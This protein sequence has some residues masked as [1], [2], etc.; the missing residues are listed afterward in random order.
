MLLSHDYQ[1]QTKLLTHI[2]FRYPK[3]LEIHIEIEKD[4]VQ[5]RLR[6]DE[7][8]QD[9]IKDFVAKK[10]AMFIIYKK[11][12]RIQQMGFNNTIKSSVLRPFMCRSPP[13]RERS[14]LFTTPFELK[15]STKPEV[16]E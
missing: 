4:A 8:S 1:K 5:R 13:A 15:I 11:R 7:F 16:T 10:C 6:C 2:L 14:W 3:T 9:T 12:S